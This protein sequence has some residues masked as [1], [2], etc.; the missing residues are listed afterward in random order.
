MS[1]D[2][3]AE[4]TNLANK[5]Q[6]FTGVVGKA[7]TINPTIR[8]TPTHE[9]AAVLSTMFSYFAYKNQITKGNYEIKT[10]LSKAVPSKREQAV[11]TLDDYY[12][13]I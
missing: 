12:H 6:L 8:C 9:P 11:I 10:K 4:H 1:F 5:E 13:F 3:H 7:Q 2:D